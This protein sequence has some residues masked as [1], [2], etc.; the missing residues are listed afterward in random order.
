MQ[1]LY[2]RK[3]TTWFLFL[4]CIQYIPIEGY[5]V[6]L[7]KMG[8]MTCAILFLLFREF[9]MS[10]ALVIGF[11]Y[12][13]FQ[14]LTASFHPESFRS[15]TLIYSVLL[16]LTYIC[17]YN[18]ITIEK[19]FSIDYFIKISKLFIKIF[20]FIAII[21]QG[22]T[23]IGLNY[24]PIINLCLGLNR[25]IGCNSL[26]IEPSHFGRFILVFYYAYIKCCEYKRDEGPFT[27]KE[28]L[29]GEHK[30]TTIY[31]LW[32]MT[33]MGSGTAFVGIILFSLYFVNKHNWYYTIPAL[34]IAYSL[35]QAS[36]IEALD[37]A[38]STMKATTTL[39]AET[40]AETDHSAS[41]R[42][43]PILNSLNVDFTNFDTWFGKGIDAG[44]KDKANRTLF[45]DYGFIFYLISLSLNI[46]CAYGFSFL[47][48]IFMFIGLAGGSGGNIQY[49]WA[50]MMIMTCVKYFHDNRY[51]PEIYEE[52]ETDDDVIIETN[53]LCA[54]HKD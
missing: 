51:N 48:V 13:I 41:A 21:Q 43:T 16:V 4:F 54:V 50:L 36:G 14:Y 40:V 18:L 42:I 25:G 34:I 31:F 26:F 47:A 44:L 8:L 24:V 9:K 35:I 49:G 52:E 7:F 17:F 37:R 20:F 28:L 33:T 32:M 45:D 2:L 23:L 6:S 39:D 53:N 22:L 3:I 30:W 10:K 38:T 29:S 5:G 27:L 46:S 15:S 12:I 19:V 11:I 1:S